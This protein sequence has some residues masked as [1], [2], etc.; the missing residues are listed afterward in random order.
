MPRREGHPPHGDF[1][2]W[3]DRG[4]PNNGDPATAKIAQHVKHC[5]ICKRT[6]MHAT[7]GPLEEEREG[8]VKPPRKGPEQEGKRSIKPRSESKIQPRG[9]KRREK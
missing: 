9:K 2:N 1:A 4:Q 3:I 5:A 8:T 6:V 7:T